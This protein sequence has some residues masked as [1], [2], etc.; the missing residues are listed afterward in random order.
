MPPLGDEQQVRFNAYD[1]QPLVSALA[2]GENKL[3]PSGRVEPAHSPICMKDMAEHSLSSPALGFAQTTKV[4]NAHYANTNT[5]C[6]PRA[7]AVKR[8]ELL[9]PTHRRCDVKVGLTVS[10]R[11]RS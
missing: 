3:S 1:V 9:S 10:M 5:G 2:N 11:V 4:G 8:G 6:N 7:E